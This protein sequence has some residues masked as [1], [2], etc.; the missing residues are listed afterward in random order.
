MCVSHVGILLSAEHW[1]LHNF[2]LRVGCA[3]PLP[4]QQL[5]GKTS[6]QGSA[7]STRRGLPLQALQ[8]S[9]RLLWLNGIL[10]YG[11]LDWINRRAVC[12]LSKEV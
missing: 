2:E 11:S 1:M 9:P 12:A 10:G 4:A 3:K 6:P 8:W 5:P 7:V